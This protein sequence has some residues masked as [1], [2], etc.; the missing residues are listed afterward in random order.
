MKPIL[1]LFLFCTGWNAAAQQLL[2]FSTARNCTYSGVLEEELYSFE[3]N[4]P[5]PEMVARILQLTGQERN[6]TLIQTNVPTVAA[7]VANGQRYLLYSQ[8][9]YLKLPTSERAIAYG[10][11]AHEIGHHVHEH[12][13]EPAFREKEELEADLFMGFALCKIQ[14]ISQLGKAM[15]VANR[16]PFAYNIP[17]EHRRDIIRTGWRRA[18]T[19]VQIQNGTMAF[20][21]GSNDASSI[22]LPS[23]PWP[24]PQCFQR[25]T[26]SDPLRTN[27]LSPLG[28]TDRKLRALDAC[29]YTQ[30]SYFQTPGGFAM[31]TQLEQFRSDGSPSGQYRWT[32]YPIREN[33][34][35][36]WSY[37]KALVVPNPGRF[38]IFVFVV[39]N[40]AYNQSATRVNK[41]DA[42]AWLGQGLN[43][44]PV[45]VAKTA[46]DD[47]HYL[48]VLIYEFEAPESTKRC[49]QKCPSFLNA[50]THLSG[51]GLS[52]QLGF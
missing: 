19:H 46:L 4:P 32:D 29:G 50:G 40:V 22:P 44:L 17:I 52:R 47:D 7:V 9:F 35:G 14:G 15:D 24:P 38:R 13:F 41:Q 21:G 42:V 27:R 30:R 8:D 16:Q 1:F 48:D 33:F 10:L 2:E 18:D 20:D 31:V 39:T 36:L 6:F 51:S 37:L 34:D 25:K 23:F 45:K 49:S 11:L 26:L 12:N 3:V 28:D 43:R 5:V